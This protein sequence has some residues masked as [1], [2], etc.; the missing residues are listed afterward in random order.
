MGPDPNTL[1]YQQRRHSAVTVGIPFIPIKISLIDD[2]QPAYQ[3]LST[4]YM[5]CTL[6]TTPHP[7]ELFPSNS[8]S[9]KPIARHPKAPF[10]RLTSSYMTQKQ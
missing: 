8:I 10:F 1:G 9:S 2:R 4:A 7:I 3:G 5:D 6:Q